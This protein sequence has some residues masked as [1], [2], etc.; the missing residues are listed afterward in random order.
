MPIPNRPSTKD[1]GSKSLKSSI[2]SPTP[3][4]LTGS[5]SSL[6]TATTL[7]P[8]ALPSSF[9]SISPLNPNSLSHCFAES[10]AIRPCAASMT[11][12][13]SWGTSRLGMGFTFSSNF[14][15][16]RFC[17]TRFI[18]TSSA[19][20]ASLLLNLPEVS[21][22]S[23]SYPSAMALSSAPYRTAEGPFVA[24]LGEKQSTSARS[25]HCSSWATAPARKVSHAASRTFWSAS[26]LRRCASLPMVV[27]FPM[28]FAPMMKCTVSGLDAEMGLSSSSPANLSVNDG[29]SVLLP[30]PSSSTL[31]SSSSLLLPFRSFPAL[32]LTRSYC[33]DPPAL[34]PSASSSFPRSSALISSWPKIS[35]LSSLKNRASLSTSSV[36]AMPRS[37]WSKVSSS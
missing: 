15:D 19:V 28:P 12:S 27:V 30:S 23:A 10:S 35:V 37:A 24:S 11:N 16:M 25:A 4:S 26:V 2:P 33:D 14:V 13:V 34:A 29:L 9:V 32:T 3:T 18:F 5:P 7:P 6:L 22:S 1:S 21:T 17:M 36:V 31:L 20:R 8:F